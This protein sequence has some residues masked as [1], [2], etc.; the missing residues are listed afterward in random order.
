[1]EN[2][3]FI[4]IILIHIVAI[5]VNKFFGGKLASVWKLEEGDE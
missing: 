5:F 4:L 2:T 3:A 1:M